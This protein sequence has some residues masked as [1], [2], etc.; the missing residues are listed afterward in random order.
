MN[1]TELSPLWPNWTKPAVFYY[2]FSSSLVILE[3]RFLQVEGIVR[4]KVIL[5]ICLQI[6]TFLFLVQFNFGKY[7]TSCNHTSALLRPSPPYCIF[8]QSQEIH[9]R[10]PLGIELRTSYMQSNS[11]TELWSTGL[12]RPVY[13]P[14]YDG[15]ISSK[16]AAHVSSWDSLC[17]WISLD[18]AGLGS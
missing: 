2:I 8:W 12:L 1:R 10:I 18:L 16:L 5:W 11:S 3:R 13:W 14:W 9:A 6:Y 7:F 4:Q 17:R 15:E